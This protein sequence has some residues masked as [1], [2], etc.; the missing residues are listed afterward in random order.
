MKELDVEI[1]IDGWQLHV[2]SLFHDRGDHDQVMNLAIKGVI[3]RL[4]RRFKDN[5]IMNDE[6]VA[7]VNESYLKIGLNSDETLM[8]YVSLAESL[9]GGKKYQKSTPPEDLSK[10]LSL[11]TMIPWTVIDLEDVVPPFRFEMSNETDNLSGLRE[12]FTFVRIPVISDQ[13]GPIASPLEVGQNIPVNKD[14]LHLLYIGFIP[15]NIGKKISATSTLA[16]LVVQ[17]WAFRFCGER[18]VRI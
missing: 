14:L 2:A 11:E 8:S 15:D 7:A 5:S 18:R 6:T 10:L 13:A 4:E 16:R 3:S 12:D 17:T 9:I 1:H